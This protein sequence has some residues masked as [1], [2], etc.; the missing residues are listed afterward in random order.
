MNLPCLFIM[1]DW[2]AGWRYFTIELVSHR[3]LYSK[4]QQTSTL[5][6]VQWGM[7][8]RYAVELCGQY[9]S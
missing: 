3:T 4:A 5:F 2:A 1:R 9:R 8:W 6:D 7:P